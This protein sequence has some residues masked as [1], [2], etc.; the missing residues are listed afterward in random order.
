[1]HIVI[2]LSTRGSN[3][4]DDRRDM[5]RRRAVGADR[6]ALSFGAILAFPAVTPNGGKIA[7]ADTRQFERGRNS[8]LGAGRKARP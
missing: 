8:I 7:R 3:R 2:E 6:E 4:E 1:M 5:T